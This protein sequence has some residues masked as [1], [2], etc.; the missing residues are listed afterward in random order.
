MNGEGQIYAPVAGVGVGKLPTARL[1]PARGQ[2]L[3]EGWKGEV[4]LGITWNR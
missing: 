1:N 2:G 4:R 3:G